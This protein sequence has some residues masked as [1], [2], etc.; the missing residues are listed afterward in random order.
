MLTSTN[1][2]DWA[3]GSSDTEEHGTGEERLAQ[4]KVFN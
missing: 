1:E 3:V 2:C 4:H